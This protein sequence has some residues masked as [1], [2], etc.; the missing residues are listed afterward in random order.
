LTSFLLVRGR[1]GHS[2]MEPVTS[3]NGVDYGRSD[4]LRIYRKLNRQRRYLPKMTEALSAPVFRAQE[5]PPTMLSLCMVTQSSM[6]PSW[7]RKSRLPSV[8]P[9]GPST[10]AGMPRRLI[11]QPGWT[12]GR[13]VSAR[14]GRGQYPQEE[15]DRVD[16]YAEHDQIGQPASTRVPMTDSRHSSRRYRGPSGWAEA[17]VAGVVAAAV[18]GFVVLAVMAYRHARPFAIDQDAGAH[19]L[20]DVIG[21]L[22]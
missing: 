8:A 17:V 22:L 3:V 18:I 2:L 12:G 11:E 13:R 15:S 7:L 4:D 16:L 5:W 21:G 20:T 10:K 19:W 6:T 14:Q 9:P 1:V